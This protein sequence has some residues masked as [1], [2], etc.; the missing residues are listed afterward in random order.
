MGT[1]T[2]KDKIF[3]KTLSVINDP[4]LSYEKK[5]IELYEI[6]KENALVQ[7]LVAQFYLQFNKE[8]FWKHSDEF[9]FK[10][11]VDIMWYLNFD[12]I[13]FDKVSENNF[14]NEIY[15]AK[16][17][18]KTLNHSDDFVFD[19]LMTLNNHEH[20]IPA[21]IDFEFICTSCKHVH[22]IFDTRCPHCHNILTFNV[23]HNLVKDLMVRNQ[24]LQ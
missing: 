22:P 24:S 8:F 7:R 15:N 3:I 16:G 5:S 14:L 19:I 9:D 12:D 13:D 4:V 17:Y 18:L 1:D 11:L 23:K 10:K 2:K 21:T 20:K 6:F